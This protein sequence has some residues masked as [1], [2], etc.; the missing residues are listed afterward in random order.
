MQAD[1]SAYFGTVLTN[2]PIG[3]EVFRFRI[4]IDLSSY[5]SDLDAIITV[6]YRDNLVAQ[7]FRF[8]DN[9]QTAR[10]FIFIDGI[11][12]ANASGLLPPEIRLLENGLV[13]LEDSVIY[14]SPDFNLPPT[15]DFDL[16]VIVVGRGG[17]NAM[18]TDFAVA[19]IALIPPPP[20][21]YDHLPCTVL[22][23]ILIITYCCHPC[24]SMCK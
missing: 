18:Q 1:A 22:I 9:D 16:S 20:G 13:V 11:N 19:T 21:V 15:L 6:L 4:V 17:A 5:G 24:R 14:I 3:T 8:G 7:T 10:V 2:A 23:I 12:T